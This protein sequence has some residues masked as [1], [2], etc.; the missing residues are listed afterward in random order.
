[1]CILLTY[2][3]YSSTNDADDENAGQTATE[4]SFAW[5][6]T[7]IFSSARC[8]HHLLPHSPLQFLCCCVQTESPCRNLYAKAFLRS[9][10]LSLSRSIASFSRQR[11]SLVAR[12]IRS[13]S[14]QVEEAGDGP[15]A[16]DGRHENWR[17]GI[18]DH[19]NEPK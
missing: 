17:E 19:D 11:N 10:M 6:A 1:M 2:E 8:E 4:F 18:Y 16:A 9:T 5:F 7:Q 14:T 13:K 3:R 12:A 15:I